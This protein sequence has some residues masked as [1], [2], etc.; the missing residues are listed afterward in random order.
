MT[1][2]TEDFN[3]REEQWLG[4]EA[5]FRVK[6]ATTI[7]KGAIVAVDS[8]GFAV[9][10]A[11]I[12]GHKVQGVSVIRA[13]NSSG[14]DGAITADVHVGDIF[15]FATT[16]ATQ[17]WKGKI[18]YVADDNTVALID[19][20]NSVKA[21]IVMRYESSTFVW[22]WVLN[23]EML[24][25]ISAT[26]VDGISLH[27]L[28]AADLAAMGIAETAGDHY[29]DITTNVITL[30][31]EEAISETEDSDSWFQ[32]R[33]PYNYAAGGTLSIRV[34]HTLFGAG[35]NNGS[36]IDFSAYEQADGAVGADLVSTGAQAMS[37]GSWTVS[38]FTVTPTGLIAGDILNI[39]LRTSVI[40]SAAAALAAK[41]DRL[42]I[43][44]Q[45]AG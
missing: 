37:K 12:A 31:G 23:D 24:T 19:P 21:G 26:T 30:L 5:P 16:G 29:L 34:N 43:V 41:I 40:E 9:P 3:R 6:A 7:W 15:K 17:A 45:R 13:D 28:R 1:A 2:L 14:A 44:Y 35:T 22:V 20:G 25:N 36:T 8:T 4:V 18:V 27:A 11:N 42:E 39:K 32:Y 33:I 38:T 10:A